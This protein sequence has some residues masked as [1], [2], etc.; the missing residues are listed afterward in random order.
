MQSPG[1]PIPILLTPAK[2]NDN[3]PSDGE[4]QVAAREL[5]NSQAGGALGM[6][7]KNV[8]AWLWGAVEEENHAGQGNAGKEDN[9]KLFVQL[10]LDPREHPPSATLEL[11]HSCL[12]SKGWRGLPWEW[13]T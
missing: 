13:A 2:I 10:V 1:D 12:E 3:V 7:T 5:L 6:H 9:W 4:I 8:N 11:E